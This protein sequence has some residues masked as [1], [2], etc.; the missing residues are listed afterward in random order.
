MPY[1]KS[2]KK[3]KIKFSDIID[4]NNNNNNNSIFGQG[5][6]EIC[7]KILKVNEKKVCI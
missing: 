1:Q 2:E 5:K 4:N 7:M 3:F 6:T